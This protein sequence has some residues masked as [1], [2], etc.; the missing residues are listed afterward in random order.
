MT[1]EELREACDESIDTIT[2]FFQRPKV[3]RAQK[4]LEALDDL[5][6]NI[7][8]WSWRNVDQPENN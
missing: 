8:K 4:A 5:R 1:E 2:D 7:T 6:A 3:S